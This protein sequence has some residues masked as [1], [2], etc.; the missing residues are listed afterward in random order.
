MSWIQTYTGIAFDLINP[1]PDMVSLEDIAHALSMQCRY[2]GH[3][4]RF[5]SVAEHSVHVSSVLASAGIEEQRQGLLHDACEAYIGDLVSP[6]KRLPAFS[7]FNDLERAI[8]IDAIAPRFGLSEV[9][10]HHVKTADRRMLATEKPQV[11]GTEPKMWG[12][13]DEPYEGLRL[14][15]LSPV[16]A[17]TV[18]LR[19]AAV[20]GVPLGMV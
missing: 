3:T 20:L 9:L 13:T 19:A 6:I 11:L 10:S 15:F 8:W 2:N 14:Q 17:E 5:Y 4:R 1:T 7:A 18:F 12:L 16:D